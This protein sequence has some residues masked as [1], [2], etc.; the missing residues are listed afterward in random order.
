MH[1]SIFVIITAVLFVFNLSVSGQMVNKEEPEYNGDSLSILQRRECIKEVYKKRDWSVFKKLQKQQ[2]Q[3]T[4]NP[5]YL[6]DYIGVLRYYEAYYKNITFQI[7]SAYYYNEKI[8]KTYDNKGDSTRAGYFLLNKAIIQKN[9]Y[10]YRGSIVNS[11]KSLEYLKSGGKKEKIAA[12]YHNLGIAHNE[13]EDIEEALKYHHRA[14]EIRKGLKE[15]P[16]LKWESLNSIG[17]TYSDHKIY[18]KA[19]ENYNKII[20]YD[21]LLATRA[22]FNA[23]VND[24]LTYARFKNGDTTTI[25]E[26]FR[27]SLHIRKRLDH[28]DGIVISN[29]HLA[30]YFDNQ[31]DRDSAIYYAKGAEVLA[32]TTKNYRDCLE[33]FNM[34][35]DILDD[36]V[37]AKHYFKKY[38]HLSDSLD[39]VSN[40]YR[41]QFARIEF[42]V[43]EK[44]E[45]I[46][47]QQDTLQK[48][49][50]TNIAMLILILTAVFVV[51]GITVY[52]FI[53]R[54][55]T[56]ID[57]DMYL[58]K[59]YKL[60]VENLELWKLLVE[61]L[62]QEEI[63]NKIFRSVNTVQTRRKALYKKIRTVQNELE[64][65][66]KAKAVLL[67]KEEQD[68][69]KNKLRGK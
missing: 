42:E 67:Y 49:E 20:A 22:S 55:R 15:E 21:S 44:E 14:Y 7:D 17:K 65:L 48:K 26:A 51:I 24:N 50:Y 45:L 38:R 63:S 66:D 40:N 27:M 19:I 33:S 68:L 6:K 29:L 30:E 41:D 39:K 59:K 35:S 11:I 57:F 56:S 36:T 37:E 13:L 43:K 69:H 12:A 52:K 53:Q 47:S 25:L 1:R 60:H 18:D 61:G 28:K 16:F 64:Y 46:Q 9:V 58:T 10:D 2:L 8:F 32:K 5:Q 62:T 54:K 34:L 3:A 4:N 31:G 23:I